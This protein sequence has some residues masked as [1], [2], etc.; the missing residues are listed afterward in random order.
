[1][2]F[3]SYNKKWYSIELNT[4]KQLFIARSKER[5]DLFTEDITIQKAI[6]KLERLVAPKTHAVG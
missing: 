6:A 2:N 4:E 1:M 5:P 3:G